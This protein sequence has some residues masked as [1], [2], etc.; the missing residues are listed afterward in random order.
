LESPG[1]LAKWLGVD[2]SELRWFADLK[3]LIH[4]QDDPSLSHYHYRILTKQFGCVRLIEAPKL[5]LKQLQR[6]ILSEILEHI[7][8]HPSVHGF[9]KRRTIRTFAAPHVGRAIVLRMDLRDFCPPFRAARIQPLF[10]PI[11]YP[12]PVAD[13]LG[14][15]CTTLTPRHVWRTAEPDADPA[16]L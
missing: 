12:E 5:R 7:P 8:S 14:G 10:R 16:R 9:V 13:L 4:K 11:G 2:A 15:I 1:D 3:G 6:K